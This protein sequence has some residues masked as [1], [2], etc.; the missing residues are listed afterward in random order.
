MASVIKNYAYYFRYKQFIIMEIHDV[1]VLLYLYYF[2]YIVFIR[3]VRVMSN[4]IDK[5]EIISTLNPII[6]NT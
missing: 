3:K 5:E 1:V 4:T 6:F 2:T